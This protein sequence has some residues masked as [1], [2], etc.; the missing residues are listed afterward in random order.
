MNFPTT[1]GTTGNEESDWVDFDD[2]PMHTI[3][4]DDADQDGRDAEAEFVVNIRDTLCAPYVE[5]FHI[6]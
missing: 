6:S 2:V 4:G 3:S 1:S 5:Y